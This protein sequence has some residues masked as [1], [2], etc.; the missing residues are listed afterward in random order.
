[1]S[2]ISFKQ[3]S[4][5]MAI[6]AGLG[7]GAA[8][9]ASAGY[10]VDSSGEVFRNTAKECWMVKGDGAAHPECGD[11]VA[12]SDGDGVPDDRDRCPDTPAG[13]AVDADG[14]PL[15]SDGDGVPDYKDRCPGT[16]AGTPVDADGCPIGT[17]EA[18]K[19][20]TAAFTVKVLIDNFDFDRS[21][22]KPGMMDALDQLVA[23]IRDAGSKDAMVLVGHTCNIGGDQYNMNLGM[24]RSQAVA[25][26][27]MSK[28]ISRSQL[29]LESMGESQPAHSNDTEAGRSKNR[30]VQIMTK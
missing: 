15:D 16:P 9:V 6:V 10:V 2:Q 14:C 18:Q 12:D 22:L 28:G 17:P 20:D 30:R 19:M 3:S 13:V 4:I 24:R 8:Q 23:K 5:M 29:K 26:Y 11:A 7:L 1:M 25:D 27:L 21:K